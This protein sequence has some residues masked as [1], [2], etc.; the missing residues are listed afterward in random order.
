MNH[1][2]GT[3]VSIALVHFPVYNKQGEIIT[4]SVTNLDL[5]D[6]SRTART[7]NLS[8]YFVVTPVLSQH[9]LAGRIMKHWKEGWGS[10]YNPNRREAFGRT[11]MVHTLAEV[12]E[13]CAEETRGKVITVVTS[14]NPKRA[15]VP[16]RD[17]AREIATH[18]DDHY[19]ILFGTGW[20]LTEEV[21]QSADVVLP[22]IL[23]NG[24]YNHLS[25]RSAVAIILDRIFT[26]ETI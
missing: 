13:K 26:T 15:T 3:N 22:P 12:Q 14:A 4:T 24:D 11:E 16:Y 7:F 2:P 9:E 8:R 25:V 20:G 19:L 5:H 6:I 21:M 18:S 10:T 1:Q 17:F 23:G